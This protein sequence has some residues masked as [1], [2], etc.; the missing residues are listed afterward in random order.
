M[1]SL[2]PCGRPPGGLETAPFLERVSL[3]AATMSDWGSREVV[4]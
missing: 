3:T 4:G 1:L 2:R